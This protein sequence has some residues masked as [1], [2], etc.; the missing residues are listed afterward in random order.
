MDLSNYISIVRFLVDFLGPNVEIRLS[1]VEKKKVVYAQPFENLNGS[2]ILEIEEKF[3]EEERYKN[4]ESVMNY[5]AF[6]ADRKKLKSATH[7]I[8]DHNNRLIGLLTINYSVDELINFRN[9]LDNIISGF[10][11]KE[12]N[13]YE[14][15]TLSFDDLM[16]NTIQ[17][18]VNKFKVSPNRLSH[19][20]KMNLIRTLDEKGTFLIKGSV[21]ELAKILNTSETTIYRYIN[22]L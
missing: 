16:T 13:Y 9:M 19:D 12:V 18:A 4:S 1:D 22:K 15:F 17:E 20:E 21:A 14:S 10:S 8:K 11:T 6:S 2:P 5:R 3:I 7:F